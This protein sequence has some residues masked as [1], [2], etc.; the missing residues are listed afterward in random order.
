MRLLAALA[1]GIAHELNDELTVIMSSADT[2]ATHLD[3]GHPAR[4]HLKQLRMATRR[5]VYITEGLLAFT[6][7]VDPRIRPLPLEAFFGAGNGRAVS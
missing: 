1:A 2:G 3:P 4:L 7:R 6:R 5:C